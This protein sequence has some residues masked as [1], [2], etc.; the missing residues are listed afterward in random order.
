MLAIIGP[1]LVLAA[2][3]AYEIFK[4]TKKEKEASE[5]FWDREREANTARKK[6]ISD[7][8][9]INVP[10]DK[11]PFGLCPAFEEVVANEKAIEELAKTKILSLKGRSNTE[12]KLEYGITNFEFL[13]KCDENYLKLIQALSREAELLLSLS[14]DREAETVL[15]YSLSIGSDIPKDYIMLAEIYKGRFDRKSLNDL[16]EKADTLELLTKKSLLE[17][18]ESIADSF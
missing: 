17:K 10:L 2:L 16:I 4:N 1:S 14:F 5:E 15:N 12:I 18:L 3:I 9:Y 7:L 6:D 8:P 11:L 13:C